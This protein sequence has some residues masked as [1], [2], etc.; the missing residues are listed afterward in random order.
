MVSIVIKVVGILK[1]TFERK[2]GVVITAGT[3]E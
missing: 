2:L 3:A 1:R